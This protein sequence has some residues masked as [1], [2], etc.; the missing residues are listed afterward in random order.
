MA[1]A[2]WRRLLGGRGRGVERG[3]DPSPLWPG[4]DETRG[5]A[6]ADALGLLLDQIE[7]LAL[8]VYRDHGLPARRGH[9]RR[10]PRARTWTFL[11]ERLSPEARWAM[12][13]ER[14][15]ERGWR[16]GALED[17]G[18]E[19]GDADTA[20]AARLLGACARLRDGGAAAGL[21]RS[22]ALAAAIQLGADWREASGARANAPGARP[23]LT[24]RA[25]RRKADP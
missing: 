21:S 4:P 3:G 5:S 19:S 13:L 20:A 7:A 14:P 15:P 12:V 1:A 16:H 8:D 11:G 24:R 6:P 17:L 9:Y 23:A 10:G 22:D 2:L 25:P 18:L